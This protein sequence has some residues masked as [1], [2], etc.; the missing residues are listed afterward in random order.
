LEISREII[1]KHQLKDKKCLLYVGRLVEVKNLESLIKAVDLVSNEISD[2]RLLMV[3]SGE[4]EVRL[5]EL[6]KSLR[7]TNEI[8]FIGRKEG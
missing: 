6:S 2:F 3:G 8:I 4:D 7:L 5:K 1:D